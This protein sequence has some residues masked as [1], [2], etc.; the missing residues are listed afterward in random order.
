M[1]GSRVT[2]E[3][4][5]KRITERRAGI[6]RRATGDIAE[7]S[8]QSDNQRATED[9]SETPG[10]SASG[11][12]IVGALRELS[13]SFQS[14]KK[15]VLEQLT[16][17][18]G[19][20]ATSTSETVPIYSVSGNIQTLTSSM[21]PQ[22]SAAVFDQPQMNINNST[23]VNMLT[24][25]NANRVGTTHIP[26]NFN[27]RD[28]SAGNN[29][30]P[31]SANIHHSDINSSTNTQSMIVP[32]LEMD[33]TARSDILNDSNGNVNNFIHH[34]VPLSAQVPD[35]IKNQIWSGEYVDLQGIQAD[36]KEFKLVLTGMGKKWAKVGV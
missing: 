22:Q 3:R 25:S 9:S 27:S 7:T 29:N 30:V 13:E 17:S 14:F 26:W 28:I 11:D 34:N 31:L 18:K 10:Q 21:S 19:T 15:T 23:N 35:K 12:G 6:N 36:E 1:P 4:R 5:S 24:T 2:R 32:G 20:K 8:S 33:M 16:V